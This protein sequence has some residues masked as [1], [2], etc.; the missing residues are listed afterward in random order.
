MIVWLASYPRSGNTFL[1]I[2]LNKM[3]GVQT[4]SLYN[5]MLDI[6][7]DSSTK[8]VVGHELLPD[9]FDIEEARAA[10]KTYFIKT[11]DVPLNEMDKVIY[12]VRDGRESTLSYFN[13][14]KTYFG[15]TENILSML[16]GDT[17][18]GIWSDHLKAWRPNSRQNTLL[19]RYEDLIS[20]PSDDINKISVFLDIEPVNGDLP[21]FDKLQKI[22]PN[23]FRS[24]KKNTWK[25]ILTQNEHNAFWLKNYSQMIEF[26]YTEDMPAIFKSENDNMILFGL[27]SQEN[28][29][30]QKILF[31]DKEKQLH[32][33]ELQLQGMEKQLLEKE[34]Q[35]NKMSRALHEKNKEINQ[36]INQLKISKRQLDNIRSH[37]AY[38]IGRTVKRLFNASMHFFR[39]SK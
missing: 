10:K 19:I 17:P 7:S 37:K 3:F 20:D 12:I 35:I 28:T 15:S 5:D 30:L 21:T 29:Y 8:E 2:I 18:Y 16:Y 14:K 13:Y 22:N 24:G 33:K 31:N 1:R 6:G 36:Q 9:D 11:H 38:K 32:E 4:Y 26:G 27:F 34:E 23:F 25:N 39:S